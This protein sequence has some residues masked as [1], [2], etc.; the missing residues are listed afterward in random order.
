MLPGSLASAR[1]Q[2]HASGQVGRADGTPSLACSER[3]ALT[4]VAC[5]WLT[6]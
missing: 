4:S 5:G 3:G 6:I 2:S 1:E